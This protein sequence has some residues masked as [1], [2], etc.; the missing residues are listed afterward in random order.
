MTTHTID[1]R[2]CALTHLEALIGEPFTDDRF[3]AEGERPC[4]L[5]EAIRAA[6]WLSNPASGV[7]HWQAQ[8]VWLHLAAWAEQ[9]HAETYVGAFRQGYAAAA[10]DAMREAMT[11]G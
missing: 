3:K 6:A 10:G 4:T 1:H 2:R 11:A 5:A 8:D 9:D 7:A